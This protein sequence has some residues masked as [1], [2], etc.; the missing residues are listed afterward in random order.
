MSLAKVIYNITTDP[1]FAAEWR[2]DPEIALESKGLKL[3]K[4]ETAFLSVA[5]NQD[6]PC[7]PKVGL[8]V[9]AIEARSWM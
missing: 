9:M 5:L 4:E 2:R 6:Y 3:S 8:S 7:T 1:E